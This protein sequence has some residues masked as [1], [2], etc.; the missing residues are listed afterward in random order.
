MK[1]S[2]IVLHVLLFIL[3]LT[4]VHTNAEE[5][6]EFENKP[7]ALQLEGILTKPQG[8]GPFPAVV[9]L[10]GCGGLKKKE[11]AEQ[12]KA[13]V[14][15]LVSW[16]YVTL[17]VDSFAP[18]GYDNIC[19]TLGAVGAINRLYDAYSARSYL[20]TLGFV[21]SKNIAVMGWSH[22]GMAIMAI[23]DGM[24]RDKG[25]KPFQAAIAFYPY[26]ERLYRF[27]TPLL[28]L[29]GDKDDWCPAS[30]CVALKNSRTVKDSKFE[31]SVKTYPN[32][33]HSFDFEGLKIDSYGHHA[34]YDPE[35]TA[36][37]IQQTKDFLAKYL[38]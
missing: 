24:N 23:V 30:Q 28:I 10:C 34:E 18:R 5:W 9:M 14:E 21:D 1:R 25:S 4:A 11:D 37:A 2:I 32:A 12:Q 17:Q 8:D 20:T 13:W 7:E 19:G 38:E 6:V 22:G 31:F 35:A 16:G 33:Y 3:F 15:R 36:D 26:C 27:D 29:I